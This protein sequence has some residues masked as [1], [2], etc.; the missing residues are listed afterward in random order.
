MLGSAAWGDLDNNGNL[1][2]LIT[3]IGNVGGNLTKIYHNN[4]NNTFS[5]VTTISLCK[6]RASSIAFGDYYDNDNNI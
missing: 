5:E 3:G 6:L 4:G 2:L 1:D